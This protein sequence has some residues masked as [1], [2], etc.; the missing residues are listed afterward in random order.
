M[1]GAPG[2]GGL[3]GIIPNPGAPTPLPGP[4]NP[5]GAYYPKGVIYTA[6]P[7][8]CALPGPAMPAPSP[9]LRVGYEGGASALMVTIFSPLSNTNP[10]ALFCSLSLSSGFLGFIFL[11]SSVSANTKFI[12]LSNAINVPTNIRESCIVTLT[13]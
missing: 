8:G 13:L 12:C 2:G 6:L 11:Y 9:I 10:S 4:A 3:V 1:G 5:Y 7:I